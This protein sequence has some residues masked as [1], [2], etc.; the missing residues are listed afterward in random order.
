MADKRLTSGRKLKEVIK[1][2]K[3]NS[4]VNKKS[5][6]ISQLPQAGTLTGNEKFPLVQDAETR[7]ASIEQIK[8]LIPPGLSPVEDV[9]YGSSMTPQKFSDV[10]TAS[11]S[12]DSLPDKVTTTLYAV[13]SEGN[14]QYARITVFPLGNNN[15]FI[16]GCG[17][18]SEEPIRYRNVCGSWTEELGSQLVYDNISGALEIP[19][20]RML[21]AA[22]ESI[23]KQSPYLGS[24]NNAAISVRLSEHT[25]NLLRLI[26]NTESSANAGL[27]IDGGH[28]V[29]PKYSEYNFD[30]PFVEPVE[31]MGGNYAYVFTFNIDN[32]SGIRELNGKK[33]FLSFKIST[34]RLYFDENGKEIDYRCAVTRHEINEKNIS[35]TLTV[36]MKAKPAKSFD[37]ITLT[38]N[39]GALDFEAYIQL[40]S[41]TTLAQNNME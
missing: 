3:R 21:Y 9:K 2:R 37:L 30:V 10:L 15:A 4:K 22:D 38:E 41:G 24:E 35:A 7:G 23:L 17:P 28:P 27:F 32:P 19:F 16:F 31:I 25:R 26:T 11:L 39:T 6:A 33:P 8:E 36:V 14:T 20:S 40:I 18:I 12:P 1:S 29:I 34:F 13:S 5:L